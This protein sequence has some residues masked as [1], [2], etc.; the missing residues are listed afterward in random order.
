M[1][2]NNKLCSKCG[3]RMSKNG[4]KNDEQQYV[5]KDKSCL[6]CVPVDGSVIIKGAGPDTSIKSPEELWE[7]VIKEQKK[8]KD[9]IQKKEIQSIEIKGKKPILITMFSDLHIGDPFADYE[10]MMKDALLV[11]NTEGCYSISAGDHHNNWIGR[12]VHLQKHQSMSMSNELS[13]FKH[14]LKVLEGKLL[15]VI[16]GN[17]DLWTEDHAGIDLTR[18]YLRG[19][20]LLYDKHEIVFNLDMFGKSWKV[21]L[22][23]KWK[24][25]SIFNPTHALEVG[26]Q[27]GDTDFDI[28]IGGHIHI[29]T[30]FREFVFHNQKKLACLIGTYKYSDTFAKMIGFPKTCGS[31]CGALMFFPD[32]SVQSWYN[33]NRA[34]EYLKYIRSV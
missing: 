26:L 1:S 12:L 25:S 3:S 7:D 27:R 18:E 33:L 34:I 17:H 15:A 32:G 29:G 2:N 24:G 10:Q 31:G 22:R 5:C 20:L 13:L 8:A 19:A 21:K 4:T 6:G 11:K 14:W 23:H 30:L 28:A 16:P 9:L